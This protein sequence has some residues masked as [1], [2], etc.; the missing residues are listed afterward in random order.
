MPTLSASATH[1]PES[2]SGE[3][4]SSQRLI[5]AAAVTASVLVLALAACLILRGLILLA[6]MT[7]AFI[8]A[9]LLA[10]LIGR[11]ADLLNW[12]R[13]PPGSRRSPASWR[14]WRCTLQRPT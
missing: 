13:V 12:I 11:V 2:G 7:M 5:R 3:P 9:L 14:C 8:A 10:A 4:S 1:S 6:P